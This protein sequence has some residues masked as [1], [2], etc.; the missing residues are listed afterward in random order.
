MMKK[1][2]VAEYDEL[3]AYGLY[4]AYRLECDFYDLELKKSKTEI[5]RSCTHLPHQKVSYLVKPISLRK[6][7]RRVVVPA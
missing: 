5:D 6:W 3:H 2:C 4:N 1:P 7:Q